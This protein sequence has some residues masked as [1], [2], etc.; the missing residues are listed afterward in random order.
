M[1]SICKYTPGTLACVM[2]AFVFTAFTFAACGKDSDD[3]GGSKNKVTWDMSQTIH[4]DTNGQAVMLITGT[5]G[6]PW[7]A[8]IVSGSDWV[9]F[10]NVSAGHTVVKSGEVGTSLADKTK[11]VYYW[12]NTTGEE[13]H[14]LV[15]FTFEDGQLP[16]EMAMTQYS[17]DDAVDVYLYGR[18][19]AW[20][21][22]P[23]KKTNDGNIDVDN[24]TYVS[25][26]ASFSGAGNKTYMARNYTLCMDKT[27]YASWW[28]AYPLHGSYTGTGRVETWAYDP[29]VAKEDQANLTKSYTASNLDR[30]HQIPNADRSGNATMQAQTFY[31]SNMTPQEAS[32]NQYSWAKLE[33]TVRTWICSDT[34]YVVTGAYWNPN[35]TATT[36]DRDGKTIPVPDYY[37]KVVVRTVA[38]NIRQAGDKLGNYPASKLQSIGFWVANVPIEKKKVV[39]SSWIRSVNDIEELTGFEFFPTIPAEVKLQK[40]PSKWGL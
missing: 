4:P 27:K 7:T 28:V 20:P 35:N 30:G 14:A 10:D 11:F 40:N 2:I 29:K 38:G 5:T 8:E 22:I 16:V 33:E 15:I 39:P 6:T 13:R 9:S 21:E 31:F 23:A 17:T 32:L 24:L 18:D 19:K 36:T 12:A 3:G 25:H 37:Y 34:L 26:F 1:K